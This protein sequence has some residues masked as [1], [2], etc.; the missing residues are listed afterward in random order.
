V[1]GNSNGKAGQIADL[2]AR[3]LEKYLIWYD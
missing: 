2:I 3:D 1:Y